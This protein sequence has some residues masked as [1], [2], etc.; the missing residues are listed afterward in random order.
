MSSYRGK[1]SAVATLALAGAL[2][3]SLLGAAPS[4][5]ADII[6]N[7]GNHPQP[8]ETNIL[9][10]AKETGTTITGEVGHTGVAVPFNS[11]TG[12]TLNQ[13][14]QGQA[15]ITNDAG[16]QLHSIGVTVPGFLFGDFI[17]NLQ[18]L[19]GHASIDVVDN[20]G[21]VA[22]FDLA[23]GKGNGSNFLTITVANGELISSVF[24]NAADGFDVFKQPRIS[25]VCTITDGGCTPVVEA[26]EPA[27]LVLLGGALLGFGALRR[28]KRA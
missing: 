18:S 26:P 4:A 27:S 24:V 25:G 19:N 28:R 14:A 20:F 16:G 5:R 7:P 13:N 22:F 12:E 1:S 21:N 17:L 10:N 6:F 2:A 15:S 8:G 3:A 11:L 9:F 23:A